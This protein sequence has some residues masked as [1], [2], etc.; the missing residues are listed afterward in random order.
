MCL[1]EPAKFQL[2]PLL[3]DDDKMV[4]P[5]V[6]HRF[7][8][9][10]HSYQAPSGEKAQ[11]A[12]AKIKKRTRSVTPEAKLS[13]MARKKLRAWEAGKAIA[14]NLGRAKGTLELST[15]RT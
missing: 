10:S 4:S 11:T 13:H 1:T 7:A 12:T 15:L 6:R 5:T 8:L 14:S 2:S 9:S 3:V